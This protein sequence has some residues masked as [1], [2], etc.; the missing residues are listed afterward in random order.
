MTDSFDFQGKVALIT[1]ASRGIGAAVAK[2]FA[3][4]GTHVILLART[5]GA[6]EEI[7]DEIQAEGG[8][9][10]LIP[11]DLRR[12]EKVDSLGPAILERFGKLDIFVGNAGVLGKLMPAHQVD[13]KDFERT[14][15]V[16]FMANVRLLRTLEPLIRASDAGRVMFSSTKSAHTPMAYWGGY[17]ASKAALN[18]FIAAYIKEISATKINAG[19]ID[20]G[21]VETKMLAEAF[22]GGYPGQTLDPTQISQKYIDF[23]LNVR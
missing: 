3:R 7:D 2:D 9:A 22:P 12:L 15:T 10:T 6:L 11:M 18:T 5:Q 23:C 14:M 21:I 13:L 20:P 4:R 19:I 8:S 17:M 16:N 1:G